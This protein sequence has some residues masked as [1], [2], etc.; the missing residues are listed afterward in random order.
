MP[1][2]G[3]VASQFSGKSFNSF[4]SIQTITVGAE[5][6]STVVF[7]SIPQTFKHLQ[8]RAMA[9]TPS[10]NGIYD[11]T[12]FNS[13]TGSNYSF[14]FL[15]GRPD[16]S[17]TARASSGVSQS[18]VRLFAWGSGP[19]GTGTTGWPAVGIADILDYTD[20]NKYTT[21]RGLGGGDSNSTVSSV[22]LTSGSWR[23]TNAITSITLTAFAVGSATT[24]AQY[25]SFALY[26]IKGV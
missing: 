9:T 19:Y 14:H 10:V 23:N 11:Q 2:L 25:S 5:G 12:T 3:T 4:E 21:I 24:F 1:I 13:D 6:Q 7:S 17:P 20:T 8:I 26:G 18:H 16:L 22:G 15:E